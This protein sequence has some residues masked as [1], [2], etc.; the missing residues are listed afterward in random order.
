MAD[1]RDIL[2]AAAPLAAAERKA[3]APVVKRP[4]GM[5]REAF[6][7]IRNSNPI[8]TTQLMEELKK[9]KKEK[10][11]K[12][13]GKGAVVWRALP[14]L[15][16]ART[17]GLQLVHWAKGFKDANGRV[18]DAHEGDYPF[19]KYNKK[20]PVYR[21]DE[22]EWAS[23]IVN[24]ESNWSREETDHL[25]GMVEQFDQRFIVIADRWEFPGGPPRTLE[26][27][28]ERYYD[29][30]RKLLIA[31]EG[32]DATLANHPLVKAPYNAAQDRQRKAA[33]MSLLDRDTSQEDADN[34]VLEQARQ[35]EE[36]RRAEQVAAQAAAQAA[37][38]AR[39][40]A[41]AAPP[42]AAPRVATPG[43]PPGVAAAPGPE[44]SFDP[45]YLV[46]PASF[47]NQTQ[48]GVP[49]LLSPTVEP[50][51]PERP[52]VYARGVFTRAMVEQQSAII[53]G[54]QAPRLVKTVEA[55]FA[56]LGVPLPPRFNSRAVTGAYLAMRGEVLHLVEL[57]RQQAARSAAQRTDA[58]RKTPGDAQAA[59]K[60]QK[61]AGKR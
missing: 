39:R 50:V 38:A 44:S 5:S 1:A 46:Y 3:K 36:R 35:I 4:E 17:D 52:G 29:I 31:R 61:V 53:L 26:D 40:A 6:E 60:R 51:R 24:P 58:K 25:L 42:A 12:P 57:R 37:A 55:A 15:N 48:P 45:A 16:Q 20:C 54:Q 13:T 43:A 28:K 27:L 11:N 14:F 19:A 23:L 21:Y 2:G 33:L 8:V 10:P 30:A 32:T 49:T 56:E 7:L 47:D 9:G 41:T 59:A 18:R 34:A 22:E